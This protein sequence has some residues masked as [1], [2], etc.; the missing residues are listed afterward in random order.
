MSTNTTHPPRET[1]TDS[2]NNNP[3]TSPPATSQDLIPS[4]RPTPSTNRNWFRNFGIFASIAALS[5]SLTTYLP[6][7][8]PSQ[9]PIDPTNYVER[10]KHVLSTT[11]LIDGHNDL[12]YLIRIELKNK[13]YDGKFTFGSGL[14]SH[15]DLRRIREGMMG[16]QFW[17]VFMECPEE[18]YGAEVGI[19]DPTWVVRDTLEQIDIAKRMVREYSDDLQYCDTAACARAA[20]K[21]GKIGS[22]LGI[23]GGHQIGNSLA[24]LRQVFDLGVRYI[25]VTHNCDNAFATSATT[26]A[27]GGHDAGLTEFGNQFVKE[28][29]RLGMLIDLSHVSHQTMRDVLSQTRAP[30][31]FSH[32]GA[33]ALS[34]HLRN[35]PDDVLRSVASNDGIVMANFVTKFLNAE[36]PDAATI[37]DVVDHI[38]HIA[39]VAGW[40]HVGVGGDFDGTTMVPK[41]IEDVSKYPRLAELMMERGATDDQVRKFAGENIL[42]VWTAVEG[43]ARQIQRDGEKPNEETWS[44]RKW[45]R[46]DLPMPYMFRDSAQKRL[47]AGKEQQ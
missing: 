15:T 32:S 26:V 44:G 9:P 39:E 8:S 47:V 19:D 38:F 12:P 31:I 10:T 29:N 16:G 5:L 2:N 22:F 36:N 23:E 37:H 17:S 13:I 33:Y 6:F 40:D 35:V 25:T 30:V 18:E 41:G 27:A 14:L 43:I 46:T 34:K 28:M 21:S 24:A 20:F 4:P 45:S 7:L 42:R 11:P 1:E 3:T